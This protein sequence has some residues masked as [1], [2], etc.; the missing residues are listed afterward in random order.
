MPTTFRLSLRTVPATARI[1]LDGQP[2]GTGSLTRELPRD[3]RSHA[4]RVTADGYQPEMLM[5][6]DVAPAE[7]VTLNRRATEAAA[8]ALVVVAPVA[9]TVPPPEVAAGAGAEPRGAWASRAGRSRPRWRPGDP[10]DAGGGAAIRARR[11]VA[12]TAPMGSVCS[13]RS[14]RV[15]GMVRSQ[16]RIA[17]QA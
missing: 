9:R 6:A 10:E 4:L 11:A 3:G 13:D 14:T 17:E 7:L 5:F 8:P 1:E 15:L 16:R 2:V 12:E